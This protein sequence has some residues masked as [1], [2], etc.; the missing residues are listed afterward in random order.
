ML[1]FIYTTKGGATMQAYE[2]RCTID[3]GIIKVPNELKEQITTLPA[4]VI[5]MIEEKSKKTK[6]GKFN[7]VRFK[8]KGFKF[9]REEAN[10]R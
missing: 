4:K 7:A 1:Y 9:D 6:S 2:F 5:V 8:T 3:D 10:A